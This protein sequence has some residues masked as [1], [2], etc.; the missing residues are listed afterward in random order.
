MI[1]LVSVVM[2]TVLAVIS[3]GADFAMVIRSSYLFGRR[4]GLFASAGIAIGV[5]VHVSYTILGVGILLANSPSLFTV[6]KYTGAVY[7]IYIGAKTFITT[8]KKTKEDDNTKSVSVFSSFRT[9]FLTNAINP[10]TMLF[11]VSTYT[12]IVNENTPIHLQISYG[13]F[14]SA[15][16]WIWFSLVALFFSNDYLRNIMLKK[17]II[18][19][20]FIGCVLFS[21]GSSLVLLPTIN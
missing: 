17:Q 18:F 15:A 1:E 10:K 20:R 8:P 12:Q 7:L 16:H 2:I 21:L 11:V 5:L 6:L 3:P 13:L 9:G 19:N 4:S 14:M